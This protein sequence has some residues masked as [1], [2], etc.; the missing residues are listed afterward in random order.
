MSMSRDRVRFVIQP[1]GSDP[2][3]AAA[4]VQAFKAPFPSAPMAQELTI[5]CRPSQFARFLIY[6]ND[7]GGRNLFKELKPELFTP[8]APKS[9][10]DVSGNKE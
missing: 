10:I 2:A 6:R 8:E 7:A 3:T 9:E 1:Y 4:F 5:V